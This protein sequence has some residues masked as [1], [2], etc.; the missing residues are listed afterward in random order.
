MH[1]NSND[2]VDFA[3]EHLHRICKLN[4]IYDT[5]F[6]PLLGH[7]ALPYS[8]TNTSYRNVSPAK[9]RLPPPGTGRVSS[10]RF[11]LNP[12]RSSL[13]NKLTLSL[14]LEMPSLGPVD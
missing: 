2:F 11:L 4:N 13:F 6:C 3:A 10:F 1:G 7:S 9:F 14:D 8:Q 5:K 12:L